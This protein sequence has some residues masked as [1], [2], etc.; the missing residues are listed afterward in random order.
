MVAVKDIDEGLIEGAVGEERTKWKR[1]NGTFKN[2]Q[3]TRW[4]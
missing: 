2:D 1:T 3:G 4:M